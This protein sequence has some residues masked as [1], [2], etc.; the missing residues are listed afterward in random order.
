MTYR[1][2]KLFEELCGKD[3]LR[4]VVLV[5][6]KWKKTNEIDGVQREVLLKDT[7]GKSMIL[8][9]SHITRFEDS[10]ESAQQIVHEILK[11]KY[12]IGIDVN[13]RIQK[14]LIDDQKPWAQTAV[15]KRICERKK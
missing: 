6:I 8:H 12:D 7:L 14:E 3:S 13:L 15:C 4:Y 5:S 9:G 11:S 1:S 2:V 10:Q